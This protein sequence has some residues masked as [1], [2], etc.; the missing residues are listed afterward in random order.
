MSVLKDKSWSFQVVAHRGF[1]AHFAENT[2]MSFLKAI[3]VGATMLELD[4][5]MTR[6]EKVVVLHDPT[7]L[8]LGG[9]RRHV[10]H[11]TWA[12]LQQIDLHD[13]E[14]RELKSGSVLTLEELFKL[15]GKTVNYYIEIKGS[16]PHSAAYERRLCER[17][18][19]LVEEYQLSAHVM[20]VSFNFSVLKY[21]REQGNLSRLGYNFRDTWPSPSKIQWLKEANAI[22]C[23]YYRL[24][25]KECVQRYQGEGFRLIPWV[26]NEP[27]EMRYWI[28]AGIDGVT[29]DNPFALCEVW[30]YCQPRKL[31]DQ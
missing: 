27:E 8:R 21:Y 16:R 10:A 13:E 4:V 6:D 1:R 11:L 31:Q 15:G 3:E 18:V 23:P 2:Y 12:E 17:V 9:Q 28:D 26:V 29:T 7:L 20:Y 25:D 30:G 24:L 5:R 22:L 14:A 19:D